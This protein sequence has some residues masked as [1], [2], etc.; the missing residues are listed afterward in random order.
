MN[1]APRVY[2]AG[3]LFGS[4]RSTDNVHR[5]VKVAEQLRHSGVMPF[6]PHL[7]HYWDAISPHDDVNYWLDMDKAW[8]AVCDAMIVLPGVSPGAR[9]EEKWCKELGI[10]FFAVDPKIGLRAA[11][12]TMLSY[13]YQKGKMP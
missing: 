9:K 13:L 6:V 7:Y 11:V 8:L 1:R 10:P 12:Q 5:A 4:G 3:P 2:V